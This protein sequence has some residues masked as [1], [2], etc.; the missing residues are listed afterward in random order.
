MGKF[1]LIYT[2][3]KEIIAYLIFGV[4]SV[5]VNFGVY[6][7]CAKLLHIDYLTSNAISWVITVLFAFI[8]NKLFV[9]ASQFQG[10]RALFKE[11]AMFV[12]LRIASGVMDMVIMYIFVDI[13]VFN[14]VVIKVVSSLVV[15][16]ANYVLSKMIVFRKKSARRP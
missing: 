3:Y 15:I 4:L 2:K 8:T 7:L 9:F 12:A 1:V 5:V 13:L 11:L 16:I 14:D 10:S 6:L